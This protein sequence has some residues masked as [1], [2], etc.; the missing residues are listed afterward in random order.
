MFDL[1]QNI[2]QWRRMLTN[3]LGGQ[4]E[5]IDELESHLREEMQRLVSAGQNPEQAWEAALTR[6]G[7]PQ[8]LAVEFGKLSPPVAACWLPA[9]LVVLAPVVI[10]VGLAWLLM[11]GLLGGRIGLLLASHVFTV[12]LGYTATFAVGALAAW[13]V[14]IRLVSGWD[15][16]RAEAFKATVGKLSAWGLALTAMGVALG[17][18][19]ARDN[20]GRYWDWDL[21]EVGGLGVAVWNCLMLLCLLRFLWNERMGILMGVGGNVVVSLSWFGPN[22]VAGPH[23]N[24]AIPGYVPILLVAFVI[25]QLLLLGAALVPV[26]RLAR[27]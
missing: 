2:E 14:L 26:G 10:A 1:E 21:R 17:A 7:G 16:R 22:L 4:A 27:R 20:L 15:A 25:A 12:T 13:S 18:W 8:Q 3:V 6:L 5:V 24:G 23:S 19:W 9:R 11:S